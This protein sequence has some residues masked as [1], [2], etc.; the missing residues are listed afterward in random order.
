MLSSQVFVFDDQLDDGPLGRKREE[1]CKYI[2]G[3]L[4]V[5]QE[6]SPREKLQPIQW[7]LQDIWRIIREVS[8]NLHKLE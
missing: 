5:L 7:V 8:P 4:A 2:D 6:D 3:A 1:A